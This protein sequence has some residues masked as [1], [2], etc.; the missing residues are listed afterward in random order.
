MKKNSTKKE[1]K[2]QAQSGL[3]LPESAMVKLS[4]INMAPYNPRTI[5]PQ[6]MA[7]LKGS[8]LKH[9]LVLNLVVQK[10]GMVLIGG[11]QRVKAMRELCKEK[12]WTL[13][14]QVQ[15]TVLDVDDATAKQLN[16]A[17]NNIEGDFDPYKLGEIFADIRDSMTLDDVVATGFGAEEIDAMMKLIS[18][19]DDEV[20]R[21]EKEAEAA[22]GSFAA[23][24]T[25]SVEFKNVEDRDEAKAMLKE[26]QA[27]GKNPGQVLLQAMRAAR[28]GGKTTNGKGKEVRK[29]A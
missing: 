3:K 9:G 1:P 28:I 19:I 2:K 6:K 18:P 22:I 5:T 15:T 11:H 25:L 14:E 21:L 20:A 23:S 26:A 29:S 8:I 4:D 10:K 16:I 27:S 7:S 13:P 24:I 12:D 17:L